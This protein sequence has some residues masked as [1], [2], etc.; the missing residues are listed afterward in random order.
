[1]NRNF[2]RNLRSFSS[3]TSDL[4]F[5]LLPTSDVSLTESLTDTLRTCDAGTDLRMDW[6]DACSLGNDGEQYFL[7]IVDKGT[8]HVVTFNT[9]TRSDPVDLLAEYLTITKRIPKF[10]RVDGAKEFVGSKMK[11][12]C[13]LHHITLQIERFTKP[14]GNFVFDYFSRRRCRYSS[15]SSCGV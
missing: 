11:D 13:H 9:K 8:E 12:F 7:V 10:L 3:A 15:K 5:T 14:I 1:M 2:Q 4:Q 6:A